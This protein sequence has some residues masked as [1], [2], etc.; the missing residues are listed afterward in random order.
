MS[1]E[2]S[3]RGTARTDACSMTE[4]ASHQLPSPGCDTTRAQTMMG[5][6]SSASCPPF[7]MPTV[8]SSWSSRLPLKCG[9]RWV[10]WSPSHRSQGGPSGM[11]TEPLGFAACRFALASISR[12]PWLGCWA[13]VGRDG[14]PLGEARAAMRA[15]CESFIDSRLGS[16]LNPGG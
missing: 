4:E 3:V 8:A 2:D 7:P 11:G 16:T 6:A 14:L 9:H 12:S 10:L 1:R 13:V 5:G 15:G